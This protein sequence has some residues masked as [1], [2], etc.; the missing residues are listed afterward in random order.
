[1]ERSGETPH[2]AA[3]DDKYQI[4]FW[5]GSTN[6]RKLPRLRSWNP[7]KM[8]VIESQVRDNGMTAHPAQDEI[9]MLGM[10]LQR[11]ETGKPLGE[12]GLVH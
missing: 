1:M 9:L 2:G 6:P 12:G 7:Q 10:A 8:R 3:V 4:A 5:Y 11:E